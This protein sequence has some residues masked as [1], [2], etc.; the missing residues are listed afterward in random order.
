MYAFQKRIALAVFSTFYMSL[1]YADQS[2][3]TLRIEQPKKI[4]CIKTSIDKQDTQP[5]QWNGW[6]NGLEQS[7]F[8]PSSISNITLK[9]LSKLKLLWAYGFSNSSK[10]DAQPTVIGN[11]IYSSGGTNLIHAIDLLTG[12]KIWSVS[13]SG[14]VR[15]AIIAGEIENK[16][17]LFFGDQNGIAYAYDALNGKKIWEKNN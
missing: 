14:R 8:Q 2:I 4:E 17:I 13:L 12:C 15:T 3:Q 6:G 9:D 10:V 11:I 5:Y 1:T 7:R 16:N